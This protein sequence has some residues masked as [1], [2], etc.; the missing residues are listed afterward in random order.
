MMLLCS[1][2]QYFRI[3]YGSMLHVGSICQGDIHNKESH[4]YSKEDKCKQVRI[5]WALSRCIIDFTKLTEIIGVLEA[6]GPDEQHPQCPVHHIL[7]R[8]SRQK[9]K[10]CGA[11]TNEWRRR[12]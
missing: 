1:C 10:P 9:Q 2:D 12:W 6:L 3:A 7:A 8:S 11:T 5:I 4:Q